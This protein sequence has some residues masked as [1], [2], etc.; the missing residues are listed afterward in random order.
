MF[1]QIAPGKLL[2]WF[3]NTNLLLWG[4]HY[5][6]AL[7]EDDTVRVEFRSI[8]PE[9]AFVV[10]QT[11]TVPHPDSFESQRWC[12]GFIA[13]LRPILES[14]GGTA[15]ILREDAGDPLRLYPGGD[16]FMLSTNT[17]WM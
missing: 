13:G 16:A 10:D 3:A 12:E 14:F 7:K 8:T 2:V 5:D 1:E 9:D 17:Q 6:S 4:P 11:G 15:G